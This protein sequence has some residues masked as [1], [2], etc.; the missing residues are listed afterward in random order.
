VGN[1]W[2]SDDGAG[3]AVARRLADELHG[4]DV[5]EHEG[6]PTS[7]IDAWA[8]A[9]AAWV[10]DAV[11]SDAAPGTLHRLD[12]S[13]SELPAALFRTSTHHVSLAETVEL[14]RAL[15]RLPARI[16]VYGIE[17]ASFETGDTLS[18]AVAAAVDRAAES[19]REEVVA[20][21]SGR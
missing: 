19:I 12:A 1:A 8:D 14:A 17:G 9:E 21:T 3:L 4:V 6:E 20:C 15:D 13:E 10:V 2:R 16:V 5:L 7:L 18:P 11:A